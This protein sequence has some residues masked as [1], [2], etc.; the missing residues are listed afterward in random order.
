[1]L[2]RKSAKHRLHMTEITQNNQ[3]C[4]ISI[5]VPQIGKNLIRLGQKE[6]Y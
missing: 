6:E 2:A 5:A 3:K 1:M 4:L